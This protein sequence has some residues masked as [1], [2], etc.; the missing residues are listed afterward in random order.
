MEK[1]YEQIV[2]H[3]FREDE[4]TPD[5]YMLG[6]SK[7][8]N[9]PILMPGG[10]GWSKFKPA[11]ELQ[12]KNGFDSINCS[13]YGTHNALETLAAFHNF[14]EF[15]KNCSERYSGVGTG[16]TQNGNT[17]HKVIEIIRNEI[18][19]IP[20]SDLPFHEGILS[21]EA[22]YY[23]NPMTR[24]LLAIGKKS[25]E[26]FDIGHDWVFAK[27]DGT[28]SIPEKQKKILFAMERGTV[29]LSV[30]AW[31]WRTLPNG[32]RRYVK[33]IGERDTHWCQLLEH[34]EGDWWFVYDHYDQ[35]EKYLDWDYDFGF[36]KVYYLSRR[37]QETAVEPQKSPV[38]RAWT[39]L[40]NALKNCLKWV[41][42]GF[43][44]QV[45]AFVPLT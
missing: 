35:V 38:A 23:P 31:K 39:F 32:E 19:V 12:V 43:N 8:A 42:K 5:M 27:G 28:N 16:T 6:A 15:P 11:A 13:N 40:W 17:P 26:I 36:A 34:K 14:E 3:G 25:I 33:A 22:Y 21:W 30:V 44:A 20:E 4:I 7:F 18:G 24:G 2:D 37:P 29:C 1:I 10:H 45:G 41:P 9:A